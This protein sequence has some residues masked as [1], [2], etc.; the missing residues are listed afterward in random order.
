MTLIFVCLGK[1]TKSFAMKLKNFSD[2]YFIQ[3]HKTDKNYYCQYAKLRDSNT[4]AILNPFTSY[5]R[6]YSL[7]NATSITDKEIFDIIEYSKSF[8]RNAL[9]IVR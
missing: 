1:T 6:T 2:H 4:T 9:L 7:K 3:M 5:L 8:I